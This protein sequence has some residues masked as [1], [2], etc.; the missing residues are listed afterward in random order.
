MICANN[1]YDFEF[2]FPRKKPHTFSLLFMC[3]QY[4]SFEKT[5]GKGENPC[6]EQFLLFPQCFLTFDNFLP[7]LSNSKLSSGNFFSF[8]E[9]KIHRLGKGSMLFKVWNRSLAR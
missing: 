6:K 5:V 8:E 7:F 3:L 1:N 4:K 2:L 9:S